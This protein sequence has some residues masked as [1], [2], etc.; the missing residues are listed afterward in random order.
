MDFSLKISQLKFG[1]CA[2]RGVH[3]LFNFTNRASESSGE[4]LV[5]TDFQLTGHRKTHGG[6][7]GL[8]EIR[9]SQMREALRVGVAKAPFEKI[10]SDSLDLFALNSMVQV[11]P[12]VIGAFCAE[13]VL[14]LETI[15]NLPEHE[16]IRF[17]NLTLTVELEINSSF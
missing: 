4:R 7:V 3:E 2:D 14:S 11:R 13:S 9:S 1:F 15:K 6:Q 10:L 16:A 12:E 5:L 8:S 17:R